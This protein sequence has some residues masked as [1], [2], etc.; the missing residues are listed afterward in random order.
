M[1]CAS[2]GYV[3]C[4]AKLAVGL[5][6]TVADQILRRVTSLPLIVSSIVGLSLY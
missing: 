3:I 6:D 4:K 2:C 1:P 5:Q